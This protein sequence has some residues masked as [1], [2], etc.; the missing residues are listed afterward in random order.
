MSGVRRGGQLVS[1]VDAQVR[2]LRIVMLWIAGCATRKG[3]DRAG[4]AG[5]RKA[6]S[7]P[8]LFTNFLNTKALS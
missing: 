3:V 4:R 6:S 7:C 5:S 1:H 2:E 8:S